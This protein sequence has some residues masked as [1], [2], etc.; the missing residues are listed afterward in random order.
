MEQQDINLVEYLKLAAELES[1]VYRQER[2]M[3][4]LNDYIERNDPQLKFDRAIQAA[5][6]ERRNLPEEKTYTEYLVHNRERSLS[7]RKGD[8]IGL[9]SF[10]AFFFF[11]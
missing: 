9:G 6:H 10:C 2:A 11:S 1:S 5:N 4:S 3:E 7:A 8:I